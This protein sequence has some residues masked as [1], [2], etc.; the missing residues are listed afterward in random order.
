MSEGASTPQLHCHAQRRSAPCIQSLF[1]AI[2]QTGTHP[3]SRAAHLSHKIQGLCIV[4]DNDDTI[5]RQ[6]PQHIQ[7]LRQHGE[8]P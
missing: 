3:D 6:P 4:G 7:E 1:R 5:G 8:F 2:K